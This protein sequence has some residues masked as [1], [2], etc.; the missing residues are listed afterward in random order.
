MKKHHLVDAIWE[1]DSSDEEQPEPN[2]KR[3]SSSESTPIDNPTILKIMAQLPDIFTKYNIHE[4]IHSFEEGPNK[5]LMYTADETG[6]VLLE[7]IG[8]EG[9]R[10]GQFARLRSWVHGEMRW[11]TIF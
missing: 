6:S 1:A 9:V 10:A 8:I 3:K 11:E 5:F 7:F 4:P 2:L